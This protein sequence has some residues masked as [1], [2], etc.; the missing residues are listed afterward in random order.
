MRE[1]WRQAKFQQV[2]CLRSN[3]KERERERERERW[4]SKVC[5][6]LE[7]I[8]HLFRRKKINRVMNNF[9]SWLIF[10]GTVFEI[11]IL[12]KSYLHLSQF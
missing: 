12:Q 6:K 2:S 5:S 8:F 1:R 3:G 4:G 7:I 10:A 11:M 9:H